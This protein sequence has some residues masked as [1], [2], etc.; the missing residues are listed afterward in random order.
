MGLTSLSL[1]SCATRT[2]VVNSDADVV[3]VG[4]GVVGEAYVH[5]PKTG[6]FYRVKNFSYPEGW[7]AGAYHPKP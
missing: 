2:V 4:K 7:Y 1:T 6:Q 5:D 3:R